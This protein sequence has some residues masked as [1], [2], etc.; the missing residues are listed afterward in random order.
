MPIR[1]YKNVLVTGGDG[2]IGLNYV[3]MLLDK[4]EELGIENIVVLDNQVA[5]SNKK[6]RNMSGIIPYYGS[7]TDFNEVDRIF[8]KYNIDCVVHFAAESHVDRSIEDPL[9]FIRTNV[10]GTG[11]LLTAARDNWKDNE[12]T[13]FHHVST[14][15]VFGE[16]VE[17]KF[18]ETDV[19]NPRS[20]YSASKASSDH[21][22]RSFHYTYGLNITISNCGN[23]YGPYQD[24]E[25][26][27]PKVIENALND[28]PIPV[29]GDG[30]NMRNWL[31]VKD[32]CSAIINIVKLGKIGHT[33]LVGSDT[34]LQNIYIIRTILEKLNKSEDLIEFVEDRLGHDAVYDI[35]S[36]K[37]RKELKWKVVTSFEENL[38]N[39]I[40]FYKQKIEGTK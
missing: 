35:D 15:E 30:T 27:I 3:E 5:G 21:L 8:K 28:K 31:Y 12:N 10:L 11:V 18:S 2:F 14:D 16:A 20:P 7:I 17:S 9:L 22:V 29:Y 4:K 6:I 38:D 1:K 23:N 33:Y 19:Y 34:T 26:L 37:I 24:T 39:T 36:S 40:E 13:L 25:K 32:H